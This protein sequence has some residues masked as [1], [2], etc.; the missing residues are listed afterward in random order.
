MLHK[1]DF[2]E[3]FLWGVSNSAYQVEGAFDSYGKGKSV[4]DEFANKKGNIKKNQNGNKATNFYHQ[5]EED[6]E[7]IKALNVQNFRFSIS[8]SRILPEGTG[9]V[10]LEGINFYDRLINSC[11]ERRITPWVTLF[12]WDLPLALQQKGGWLNRDI[13][14]WFKEYI[15]VCANYFGDRVNHWMIINEPAAFTG[16]GY[17]LGFHA[18]GL[19]GL[20]NFL[21]AAHHTALCIAT[22]GE[23]LKQLLPDSAVGTT[24]SFSP[25]EPYRNRE[26]DIKAAARVDALLNRFFLEPILGL[27]YPTDLLGS[28]AQIEKYF[29]LGDE[30][31]LAFNFDFIG[32]QNYSR[33]V[34]T[35]SYFAPYVNAKLVSAKKRNKPTTAM[36]WENYPEAIF[37]ILNQLNQYKNIP[38][39][40][41]TECGIALT[42]ELEG[43][44][45]SDQERIEFLTKSIG[46]VKRFKE[47]QKNIHGYF[48]WSITDNFE[49]AEGYYPRFGLVHID[50]NSFKRTPKDSYF[51]LQNFLK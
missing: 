24:F 50:Y 1:Q 12:H 10:N 23:Y 30:N 28:F 18:P 37:S 39:L 48:I 21:P 14:Q 32:V 45:V 11:I 17:F 9:K 35:H 41:I 7:L 27:G 47:L 46:E 29:Q 38:K 3:D 34:I 6:V 26:K 36:D 2:G 22:G 49:W 33:E 16:L 44:K 40:I 4:W 8:W 31:R 20:N 5:Y 51:W 43:N 13:I 42:D 25:I 15:R 19:K